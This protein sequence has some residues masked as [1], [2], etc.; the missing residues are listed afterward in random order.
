MGESFR[1]SDDKELTEQ[2]DRDL[3]RAV[4][5]RDRKAAAR[6][7]EMF[8]DDVYSLIWNRLTPRVGAVDDLVQETFL[9][10]WSA[11]GR[12][13]GEAPLRQWILSIA[14]HKVYDYYRRAFQWNFD[15][16]DDEPAEAESIETALLE[17]E[18]SERVLATLER[19]RG[20]YAALLR[21]RYWDG[22]SAREM[23]AATGKSEKAIERMLARARIEF[24]EK[25]EAAHGRT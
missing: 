25:W 16:V 5:A 6:F 8:A 9:A 15:A 22:Q 13:T 1:F 12:Y 7:V 23:A 3:A 2:T 4:L 17:T 10:A 21:W 19:L 18:R 24:R 20:E 14:R 11:L